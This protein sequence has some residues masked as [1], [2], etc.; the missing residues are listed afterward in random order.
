VTYNIN[1]TL[2]YYGLCPFTVHYDSVMFSRLSGFQIKQSG[3]QG[4]GFEATLVVG[5]NVRKKLLLKSNN[6]AR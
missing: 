1:K 5:I 4:Q 6:N 3:N 2:A